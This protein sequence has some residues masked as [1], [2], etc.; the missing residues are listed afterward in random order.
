MQAICHSSHISVGSSCNAKNVCY[1]ATSRHIVPED[2]PKAVRLVEQETNC[3]DC[4][5]ELYTELLFF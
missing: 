4:E 1:Y 2:L 5:I 3:Y